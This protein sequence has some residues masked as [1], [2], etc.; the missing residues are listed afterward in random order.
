MPK[1]YG[2]MSYTR[3]KY[4]HSMPQSMIKRFTLGDAKGEYS[5]VTFLKVTS[6]G[7]IGSGALEAARVTANKVLEKTGGPFMLKV[8]VYPHEVV[9]EHKF[10]GFAGADRLS[11]GMSAS[12]GRPK[13]RAAKVVAGQAIM[14]IYTKGDAVDVAR[15]ALKRAS[16]KLPLPYEIVV[17]E[18]GGAETQAEAS[19]SDQ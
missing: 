18:T 15:T 5:H 17:E 19:T 16:K 4:V 11:R 10:M 7:E 12:F 9:R 14:A 2:G 6:P 8:F 3:Q 1:H 13:S